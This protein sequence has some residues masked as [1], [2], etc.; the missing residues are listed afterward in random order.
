ML[1]SSG[2]GRELRG[3]MNTLISNPAF[4]SRF[5][6]GFTITY[7]YL[8]PQLT[9]GLAWFIVYWKWRA[10]RSGNEQYNK[11]VRFW[12]KIFGLNFAVGVVTGIPM[13]F[14]FGT[15]WAG[16]THFAG[17]VIGQTLAME[18]M[19]AFLLESAF[20]GALIW[21]EKRLGPRYHFLSAVAV[22]VGSW[23][24]GFFI[25]V[26]NAFMQHP[27]GF[28]FDPGG[29]LGIDSVRA[30]LLNPWA[31]VQF[32]H[33]QMAAVVTASFVVAAVGAFYS[34]R[35]LHAAQ[36]N[37]YLRTG[38]FV[39]LIAS[40][41]VAFPT[42]DQQA[43]MVGNHQPVTLA[44][45]EGKFAGGTKAGVAMIGQP[46]VA[47]G[48]LDNAIE[49]PG[50]LSFLAYGHLG[51]YVHGLDEY[52]KSIWPDNI[53][54]LYYSFH[55]MIT[56]GTIFIVLMAYA[57][58]EKWRG[59]LHSNTWLLWV[60]MLASPFPYIA[61]TLGWMTAELGR[62]PWL[63]YGLLQTRD[64]YSKVVSNGDT[65]F[66]LIGFVNLYFVLGVLFL[67]LVGREIHHGPDADTR[68][69]QDDEVASPNAAAIKEKEE[70]FV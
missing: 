65:I 68:S 24:S 13:E 34:L 32:T 16:F 37:L 4:W 31:L 30:Y 66:T 55:L 38:T 52:P 44:A 70:Y 69:T 61:N 43:K 56:L 33:N 25:L 60:L 58:F 22:A 9:M 8:F 50:A 11:A 57:N 54:L 53:E 27:T 59:R 10:L 28:R 21:G 48:R 26:T 36:A 2:T 7:H 39:A 63:I 41:L 14:Q 62:Q 40:L 19:F 64:G 20:V 42:G 51:S 35:R 23:L 47:D 46:D 5:Q 1:A 6:F 29:L 3:E 15:N 49:L 12:S 67:Y 45:M 17:G 18:G